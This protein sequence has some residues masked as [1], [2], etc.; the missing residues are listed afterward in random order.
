MVKNSVLLRKSSGQAFLTE[1]LR[2][3]FRAQNCVST[4]KICSGI[5]FKTRNSETFLVGFCRE[6]TFFIMQ[7]NKK[8]EFF[9]DFREICHIR[10][11][12]TKTKRYIQN[13]KY[14]RSV[15]G[16]CLSSMFPLTM[17][18][19]LGCLREINC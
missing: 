8:S 19:N 1:I 3:F 12:N 5:F 6:R 13:P 2:Q 10:P 16:T 7:Q 11:K 14:K 15:V 17:V 9:R 4:Q 18:N